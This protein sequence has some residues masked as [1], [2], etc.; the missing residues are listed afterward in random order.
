M[1]FPA[2]PTQLIFSR[3]WI[4]FSFVVAAPGRK[5]I[6]FQHILRYAQFPVLV[7]FQKGK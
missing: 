4:L 5:D 1:S 6:E 2:Y 3:K 7:S